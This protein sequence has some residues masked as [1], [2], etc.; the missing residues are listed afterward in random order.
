MAGATA[1]SETSGRDGTMLKYRLISGLTMGGALLLAMFWMPAAGILAVLLA[2]SVGGQ[3]EFYRMLRNA[4]IPAFTVVGTLAGVAFLAARFLMTGP[5]RE[6]MAAV[7]WERIILV[8]TL[9]A[10]FVRQFPQ[11]YNTR[12]FET[13]GWSLVVVWYVLLFFCFFSYVF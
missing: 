13:I 9:L 3:V 7:G 4:G 11:K 8:A 2:L 10:V 1:G 6:D 12:P 5:C